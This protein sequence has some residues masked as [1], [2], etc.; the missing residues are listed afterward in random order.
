ML[1]PPLPLMETQRLMSLHSLRILDTPSEERFD[2]ITRMAQRMFGVESCL[3]SLVDSGR[4]WFKSKQGLDACETSREISFCGHTILSDALFLV[5]DAR[6]DPR[7]AD[8]PL[9]TGPPNIRFYAGCPIRGPRGHRIGTL[10]ML[11][12]EPRGLS[13]DEQ[14][15]LKDLAGL[16]EDELKMTSQAT[17]DELTQIANRRGFNTVA[18]HMLSLCRRTKLD[19]ELVFFDLDRFKEVN[20]TYGHEAGDQL[21]K[22]FAKLLIK[23]FRAADVVARL[24]GDEFVVLMTASSE[25]SDAALERLAAMAGAEDSEILSRLSW[26][27]GTISF[28][29]ERH[30]TVD[31][32]LADADTTMYENKVQRRNA[33]S[34]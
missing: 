34:R 28:D 6:N 23:C 15:T 3:I 13:I 12:P 33:G 16:V 22:H 26:S 19:A 5:D 31:A 10:C 2:R 1:K 18:G 29:P 7:F 11:D 21:L 9:V 25:I 20:D 17:V 30:D 4:Q 27:V 14:A 24:G 8:N 32:L